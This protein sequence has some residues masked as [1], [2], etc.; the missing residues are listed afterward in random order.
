MTVRLTLKNWRPWEANCWLKTVATWSGNRRCSSQATRKA[1]CNPGERSCRA[2]GPLTRCATTRLDEVGEVDF[3]EVV[4]QLF[5]AGELAGFGDVE[6]VVFGLEAVVFDPFFDDRL[7][8]DDFDAGLE[9]FEGHAGKAFGVEFAQLILVIVVIGRAEDGAAH[10]ALGDESISAPGRFGG[11]AFGLVKG[12]E[13]PAQDV[14]DRLVLGKPEGV[15]QGAQKERLDGLALSVLS[16]PRSGPAGV[17]ASAKSSGRCQTGIGAAGDANL[18]GQGFHALVVGQN[19]DNDVRRGCGR[20]GLDALASGAPY[21]EGRV[22]GGVSSPLGLSHRGRRDGAGGGLWRSSKVRSRRSSP[23]KLA[24]R[25]T[26]GDPAPK[27]A[28]KAFPNQVRIQVCA[29]LTRSILMEHG[30]GLG[31]IASVH[32]AGA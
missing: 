24:Y 21:H 12:V 28:G 2:A 4:C 1:R 30:T 22:R 13:M 20:P 17:P 8:L 3:A 10:A 32:F 18:A 25:L 15:I 16:S 7:V 29:H 27:R 6:A 5:A 31:G 9:G 26:P 11:G 19:G 14:S 23:A